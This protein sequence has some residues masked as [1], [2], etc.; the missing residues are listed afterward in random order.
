MR[1]Y[2]KIN[3]QFWIGN[4]GRK[5]RTAGQEAMLVGLYLLSNPHANMLGLYYLPKLF[6]AH[7]TGLGLKGASEGLQRAIEA[8]FCSYDECS[9]I[10]F[11]HEMARYQIADQLEPT[12]KQCKGI[13]REYDGLPNN[14]FLSVFYEKYANAFHLTNRRDNGRTYAGA[15]VPL[16]SQEQ[17]QEQE[18]DTGAGGAGQKLPERPTTNQPTWRTEETP[19]DLLPLSYAS[20]TLQDLGLPETRANL[21]TVAASITALT[22]DGPSGPGKSLP[23]AY[24]FLLGK[25]RDA[26]TEGVKLN[27]FWFED[28]KWRSPNERKNEN[29]AEHRQTRNLAA[30]DA[31]RAAVMGN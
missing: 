18:Q 15:S 23:A 9:E 12:D 25:A 29:R 19:H 14:P 11:I 20:R 22:H 16:R 3:P 26:L 31:A 7:E 28:S 24:E 13:Q 6:I 10:V 5:L 17:E 27:K 21:E 2:A 1:G 8:A 30:R 4:T